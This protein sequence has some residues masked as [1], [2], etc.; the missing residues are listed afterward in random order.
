M[1]VA[2]PSPAPVADPVPEPAIAQA[3]A[4]EPR[5][6]EPTPVVA[7]PE[8][9]AEPLAPVQEPAA[10][11]A[12]APARRKPVVKPAPRPMAKATPAAAAAPTPAPALAPVAAPAR[13]PEPPPPPPAPAARGP[14]EA[15]A[16]GERALARG[17]VAA[18]CAK[19]EEARRAAPRSPAVHR[20]LGKC[21]LR[22]GDAARGRESYRRY[23]ELA[24]DA[25][26]AAF[27]KSIVK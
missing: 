23:L 27:I 10:P 4:P 6:T 14:E 3:P 21:Y 15:L 8:P 2:R 19:G 25:P 13:A 16:E 7:E 12:S 22:A 1:I 24:P 20:F 11:V 9:T 26:D 17:D 18:A 5:V